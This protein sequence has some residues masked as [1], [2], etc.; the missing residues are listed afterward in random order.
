[1]GVA[2]IRWMDDKARREPCCS[3]EA[4]E[5]VVARE[6]EVENRVRCS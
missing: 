4:R 3:A 1:M 6:G 2:R 5:R